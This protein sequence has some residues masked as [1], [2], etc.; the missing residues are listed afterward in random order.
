METDSSN[1]EKARD[2]LKTLLNTLQEQGIDAE[3]L[4]MTKNYAKSLILR[5]NET[6][7]ERTRSLAIFQTMGLGYGYLKTIL[8]EMDKINLEQINNFIRACLDPE[9]R[10][11]LTIGPTTK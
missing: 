10:L 2:S 3:E 8:A 1:A 6:K 9:N 4:E 5:N 7:E 11:F